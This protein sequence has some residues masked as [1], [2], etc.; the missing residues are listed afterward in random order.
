[1]ADPF[2]EKSMLSSNNKFT[3]RL[4]VDVAPKQTTLLQQ[5]PNMPL[6][7]MK[8]NTI[9][10]HKNFDQASDM[11][12]R[13][14]P[15]SLIKR[16]SK[17]FAAAAALNTEDALLRLEDMSSSNSFHGEIIGRTFSDSTLASRSEPASDTCSRSAES[18]IGQVE[19]GWKVAL[20]PH[21]SNLAETINR[22]ADV[23]NT[24]HII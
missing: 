6:R 14:K 24:R 2:V 23:G 7:R 10:I 22:I 21:Y 15:E 18:K 19:G 8:Y 1:M 5:L 16:E 9:L 3:K 12:R 4:V 17:N 11:A 13:V 20:K